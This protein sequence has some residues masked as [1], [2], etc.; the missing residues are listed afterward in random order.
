MDHSFHESFQQP[1]SQ[2][3]VDHAFIVKELL[4][5]VNFYLLYVVIFAACLCVFLALVPR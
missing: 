4:A 5:S 2:Y 3:Q 1:T